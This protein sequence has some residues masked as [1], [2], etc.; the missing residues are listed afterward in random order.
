MSI[1]G[2]EDRLCKLHV[3]A[4][5]CMVQTA[6]AG[7]YGQVLLLSPENRAFFA[8]VRHRKTS[9]KLSN[10]I[11]KS[12]SRS[13]QLR[14]RNKLENLCHFRCPLLDINF[15]FTMLFCVDPSNIPPA[16]GQELEIFRDDTA[17]PGTSFMNRLL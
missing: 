11:W 9:V 2:A 14:R 4:V 15:A 17:I 16:G 13:S 7:C 5:S 3:C 6:F 8:V 12:L 1:E 10:M